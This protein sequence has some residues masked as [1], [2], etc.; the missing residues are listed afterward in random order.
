M[1]R[2]KILCVLLLII[3]AW[4]IVMAIQAKSRAD[5]AEELVDA[6]ASKELDRQRYVPGVLVKPKIPDAPAGT[7]PILWATGSVRYPPK[8]QAQEIHD[9][10]PPPIQAEIVPRGIPCSLDD[11]DVTLRCALDALVT[12]TRPW[13][14]L[15]TSATITG[16]GQVRELEPTPA[17]DVRLEVAPAVV[18]PR[19][20]LDLLG[21]IAAGSRFGVEAGASWTGRSRFGP[22]FLVE[23]QPSTGGQ[24]YDS[25]AE[26][27]YSTGEPATWRVHGGFRVRIR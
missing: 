6:Y 23:W 22:Y 15:V 26:S 8:P 10:P 24:S 12:P 19:W 13:A 9:T 25:Y 3:L 5:N 20:H 1:N 4:V 27:Y 17:G 11:L 16:Y 14:K 2:W 7:T 18:A 21:G